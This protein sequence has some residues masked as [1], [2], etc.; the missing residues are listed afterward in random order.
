M[1]QAQLSSTRGSTGRFLIV[2]TDDQA[3]SAFK[4][5]VESAGHQ[6]DVA[7]TTE[8]ALQ[9][10]HRVHYD[11]VA[12]TLDGNGNDTIGLIRN[13]QRSH[14]GL[15]VVLINGLRSLSLPDDR[16]LDRALV[17]VI[18]KPWD[19][20]ELLEVLATAMKITEARTRSGELA[21]G[22]GG[23][24]VLLLEDSED[25]AAIFRFHAESSELDIEV[26]EVSRLDGALRALEMEDWDLVVADLSLPDARGLD[27][28]RR[29]RAP[30]PHLPVVV[31]SGTHDEEMV[32]GS[33]EL[34]AHGFLSKQELDS[35][36]LARFLRH[37]LARRRAD[38]RLYSLASQDQLTGLANRAAFNATLRQTLARGRRSGTGSALL[39]L[40]LDRFKEVNDLCGHD[41]G[42]QVLRDA[43]T[44]L[45]AVVREP[46]T[47]ARIGGDEFL[48]LLE[49]VS[50]LEEALVAVRRICRALNEPYRVEGS[51]IDVGCSVGVALAP[52]HA[53][54]PE[55]LL[56]RADQ[57]MY[58]AKRRGGGSFAVYEL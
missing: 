52:L 44:R 6:V 20:D 11:A 21:N 23:L 39:F 22:S 15:A 9:S 48:V 41:C 57:A 13:L 24:K 30:N 56:E 42:D 18:S 36:S 12:A 51:E 32:T 25:D 35:A 38:D 33:L 27:A 8:E 37:A 55:Q 54:T 46:D 26:S 29:L 5:Q 58:S 17:S 4:Q 16:R 53:D 3:R 7:T 19:A 49:D 14:P 28:V 47:L 31:I 50:D 2:D 1:Q 45:R 43:A 40:D 10:T 34:G